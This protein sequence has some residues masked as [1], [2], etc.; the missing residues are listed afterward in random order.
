MGSYLMDQVIVLSITGALNV[1][2]TEEHRKEICRYLYNH[3]ARTNFH[4]IKLIYLF[5]TTFF[6]CLYDF[7]SFVRTSLCKVTLKQH[8]F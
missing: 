3:Q 6:V 4:G 2:L 5:F 8:N 7:W 1:V